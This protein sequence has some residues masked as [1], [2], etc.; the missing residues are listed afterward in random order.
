MK[1][2]IVCSGNAFNF[3]FEKHQAFIY[4]Q[5]NSIYQEYPSINFDKFFVTQKGIKGY[6]KHIKMLKQN[7]SEK[8]YDLLHAH[9][10]VVGL[11]CIF[12]RKVPVIVTFHGSDINFPRLNIISSLVSLFAKHIIFVSEKLQ[13]KMY[14][15]IKT[16]KFSVIPCGVDMKIFK[17]QNKEQS[18]KKIILFASSFQVFIKNS[19]FAKTSVSLIDKDFDLVELKDKSRVEV[20]EL[21]N[22]ADLLLLTSFSEGSPQIIKEAMACNCPIVSTDVGD[23][24]EVIGDTKG[25]YICSFDPNDVADKIKAALDF[26]WTNGRTNGRQRII[27][28]GLDSET[29]AK[30]IIE[31]YQKVLKKN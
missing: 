7:L 21:L 10:S 3:S 31:V 25:C 19:E 18:G 30:K 14:V 28:M 1:V 29:V 15:K 27:E 4:D 17:P 11:L 16:S 13:K 22:K 5:V 2:L 24:R 26:A 6:W 20:N 9:N 12:Q 23:V 8:K